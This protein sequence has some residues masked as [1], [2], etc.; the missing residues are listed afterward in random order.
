MHSWRGPW[1]RKDKY[2]K[3]SGLQL[4][5]LEKAVMELMWTRGECTV[6]DLYAGFAQSHAYT[7]IMTTLDRLHKKG[8]LDRHKQ[9]KAFCYSA[10]LTKPELEE[11]MARDLVNMLLTEGSAQSLLSCFVDAIGEHDAELLRELEEE[12][13]RRRA[14][15]EEEGK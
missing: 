8:L 7:T 10:R 4:G 11:A 13:R 1:G 14:G 15:L 3:L 9:G 5:E 12:V 6:R 2:G